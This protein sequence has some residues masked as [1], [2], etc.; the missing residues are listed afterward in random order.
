MRIKT[1]QSKLII[2]SIISCSV[3]VYEVSYEVGGV[4]EFY[5]PSRQSLKDHD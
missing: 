5:S 1:N 3:V 2:L 4:I